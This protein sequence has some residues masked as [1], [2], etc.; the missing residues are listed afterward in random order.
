MTEPARKSPQLWTDCLSVFVPCV[1]YAYQEGRKEGMKIDKSDYMVGSDGPRGSKYDFMTTVEEVPK[2][3]H[4]RG[5]DT[6]ANPESILSGLAAVLFHRIFLMQA[7][8]RAGGKSKYSNLI[9]G[10]TQKQRQKQNK[11]KQKNKSIQLTIRL[12]LSVQ[13]ESQRKSYLTLKLE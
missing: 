2:G 13:K 4:A 10:F 1:T 3:V 7:D 11:T 6:A 12:L 8:L 9:Q 5:K